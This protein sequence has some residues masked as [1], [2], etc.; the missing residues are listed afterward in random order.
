[1]RLALWLYVVLVWLL[2]ARIRRRQ[3]R[4]MCELFG[5]Q[6]ASA[7]EQGGAG[8][9]A[10]RGLLDLVLRIPYEHVRLLRRG[11]AGEGVMLNS[12]GFEVRQGLRVLRRQPGTSLL[13]VVMLA[14]GI[15]ANTVV[16]SFVNTAFLRPLPWD[17]PDRLVYL[18]ERAPRWN[19]EYTGINYPDFA[20]WRDGARAFES[21]ALYAAD[22]F[23]VAEGGVAERVEGVAITRDYLSVLRIRPLHGRAFTAAEDT[24]EGARVVLISEALWRTRFAGRD[25]VLGR[26]LRINSV[27]HTIVGVLPTAA[28]FPNQAQIWVPL[29]GD[30]GQSYQSYAF[31][32][33]ARLRAGVTVAAAQS[34]LHRVQQAIWDERDHDRVVSPLVMPLADRLFGELRPALLA[35]AGGV[36]IILLITCAN[37][38]SVML[39]RATSRRR[40]VGIRRALGA[41]QSRIARQVLMENGLLSTAGALVGVVA[42]LWTVRVLLA[43]LPEE[44]P[45]WVHFDADFRIVLFGVSAAAFTAL[46][47]GLAPLFQ[48]V[49][50]DARE[51]LAARASGRAS[52][53]RGQR[54][55]L[56]GLVITEIALA[57][58]LLVG[59][60]LLWRAYQRVQN[61]DPGY[62]PENVLSFRIALPEGKY[63]N[64]TTRRQFFE[65]ALA[66]LSRLPGV[67]HAGAIT[68]PPL[69]C[70]FGNFL[71]I[72]NAPPRPA[73]AQDPV[74]LVRIASPGY[75]RAIG[76]R[77][78][79]GRY[80]RD[81]DLRTGAPP[82][83][84]VNEAFVNTF[85]G[86]KDPIGKRVR[87]R[88]D[89]T[90]QSIIGVMQD[91]KHYGLNEPMR[92]GVYM[93]MSWHTASSMA[94]LLR[95]AGEPMS[96]AANARQIIQK[97]DPELPVYQLRTMSEALHESLSL[98]RTY[99]WFLAV[100]AGTAL[101][102]AVG[103]IYGVLS[104]V[105]GQRRREISI[106][107]AMGARRSNV[108]GLVLRQ[109]ATLASAGIALGVLASLGVARLLTD[110]LYGV[111]P[112][113]GLTYGSV[114]SLL[115]L[116]AMVAAFAPARRA[117]S[118]EPQSALR[119]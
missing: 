75:E 37:V 74:V 19:L 4:A 39:A 47:A 46:A 43:W 72:E 96:A 97:L 89:S 20:L 50:S 80:F 94:F 1:M 116:T 25:N 24:P 36:A 98:Q 85:Y 67:Q 16:F 63:A 81:D 30:R 55:T 106:R 87:F 57:C 49:A 9:L 56:N 114:I 68:C 10:L 77:A 79:R 73:D 26:T 12:V 2:P 48:N 99:S 84:V 76:L 58:V 118:V 71:D 44:A 15:A 113:D 78:R 102:L 95:V 27:P 70:H 61:V 93:P 42:G 83:V 65:G 38:S 108:L 7:G 60:G 13:V 32:G 91:V 5:E 54:H 51:S 22:A 92:P 69:E 86:G 110:L 105:V 31:D 59:G 8:V 111:R 11:Y 82:S 18:N 3:G 17:N 33:I 103:G 112:F 29:R 53:T 66:E 45:P 21:M 6:L 64:D 41:S 107:M 52:A 115:A 101:T 62:N 119:E 88:G 35:L 90:W 100:F 34:D 14:L 109:G 40:E 28:S 117:L 23:N 104:Y